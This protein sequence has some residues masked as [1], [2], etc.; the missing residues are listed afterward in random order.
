MNKQQEIKELFSVFHDFEIKTVSKDGESLTLG[1]VIPWGQVWNPAVL[2]YQIK[3]ELTRCR[4][5]LCEYF[6]FK[7]D[8]A[9]RLK[10]IAFRGTEKRTINDPLTIENLGLE[11][12]SC[13]Y[14]QPDIYVLHCNSSRDIAGG[15]LTLT[16]TNYQIFDSD[17]G[18]LTLNQLK[19]WANEWWDSIQEM[20][21][22]QKK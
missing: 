19:H 11:V 8:E 13:S 17:G 20:W 16:A 14:T 22:E 4:D 7:D 6:T 18:P 10:P 3:V 1:F 15:E 2:E 5:L 12:Q 21:D 9:N